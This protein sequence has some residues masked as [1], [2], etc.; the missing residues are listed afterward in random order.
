MALLRGVHE[1]LTHKKQAEPQ[2]DDPSLITG[3]IL[4]PRK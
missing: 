4:F 1:P 2:S 3:L